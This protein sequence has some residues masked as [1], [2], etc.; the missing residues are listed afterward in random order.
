M[1]FSGCGDGGTIAGIQVFYNEDVATVSEAVTLL[2]AGKAR[3][4]GPAQVCG[5]GP[6]G[7]A[8]RDG[9]DGR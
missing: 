3:V 1:T 6:G 7:D 9:G 2:A 8:R 5:G 4:F